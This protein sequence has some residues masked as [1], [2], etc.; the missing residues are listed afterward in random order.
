MLDMGDD[1]GDNV[2]EYTLMMGSSPSTSST[3]EQYGARGNFARKM[4]E[5]RVLEFGCSLAMFSLALFFA[6]IPVQ[7]RPIPNVEVRIN[8]TMTVWSRDPMLNAKVH[9]EQVTTAAL[10]FFGVAIPVAVNL[11]MNYV[12]PRFHMARLVPYDTRDFLL[13]LAQSTS[14]SELLTEF[15]KNLTGQFRPSFYDMCGWQYQ[16]VWDG[17]T[18]LCTD[19]AGEKEGRKSFPSGHASFAWSTMLLLTVRPVT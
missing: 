14:M 2:D 18:N 11:L 12:V 5:S 8:S 4:N 15:T 6:I 3:D 16:V 9:P 7:Q 17:V 13:S 1:D 19:P 10:V